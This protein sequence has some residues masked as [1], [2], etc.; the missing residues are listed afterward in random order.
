MPSRD[1]PERTFRVHLCTTVSSSGETTEPLVRCPRTDETI[2]A[3]TCA[4]CMRM[5]ALEWAPGIGGEVRCLIGSG[6]E[7]DPRADFA[8]LAARTCVHEILA[9]ATTCVTPDVSL[10][11]VRA[12]FAESRARAV[13]VVDDGGKLQALVSRSDL[14]AAPVDGTVRDVMTLVVHALPEDAPI[15]Y[16]IAL[17]GFE[18]IGEVPVVKNDG[19]VVGMCHALDIL[20][21]VAGR[22]G[23]TEAKR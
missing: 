11:R 15:A 5:R 18:D 12:I 14:I 17:L 22:L 4:G 1:V 21:W 10:A 19:A 3:R 23:Y 9:R 6:P 13:P 20:R 16:A 8:E 7:V 2:D